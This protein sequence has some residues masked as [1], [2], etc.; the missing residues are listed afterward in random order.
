[1]I[2]KYLLSG[3]KIVSWK[4]SNLSSDEGFYFFST[5]VDWFKGVDI[6]YI[7]SSPFSIDSDILFSDI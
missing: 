5:V 4:T 2:A 7:L 1:M 6:K 3:R